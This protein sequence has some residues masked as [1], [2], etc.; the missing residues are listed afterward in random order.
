MHGV[1]AGSARQKRFANRQG[2]RQ[3]GSNDAKHL[4]KKQPLKHVLPRPRRRSRRPKPPGCRSKRPNTRAK[5]RHRASSSRSSGNART[6]S[7]PRTR[8]TGARLWN[9][10]KVL[11]RLGAMSLPRRPTRRP[12]E[13]TRQWKP[14][15]TATPDNHPGETCGTLPRIAS[16][17]SVTSGRNFKGENFAVALRSRQKSKPGVLGGGREERF[18]V[19]APLSRRGLVRLDAGVVAAVEQQRPRLDLRRL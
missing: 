3:P 11:V 9:P 2:W 14:P 13:K 8:S 15:T 18:Q 1:G 19:V 10:N 16:S 5:R 12:T 17:A 7:P 4:G 6:A